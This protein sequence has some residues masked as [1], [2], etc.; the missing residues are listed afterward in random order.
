MTFSSTSLSSDLGPII[1]V[2][3]QYL[4]ED[5]DWMLVNQMKV[6]L[7]KSEVMVVGRSLYLQG[8]RLDGIGTHVTDGDKLPFVTQVCCISMHL[9]FLVAVLTRSSF[10]QL[11]LM[12]RL[13]L[14]FRF[15]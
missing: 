11:H 14:S 10:P 12:R 7:C 1:P 15:R 9:D 2:L 8:K 13:T 3:L 5:E 6:N 4:A